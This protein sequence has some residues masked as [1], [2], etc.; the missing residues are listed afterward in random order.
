MPFYFD[1][2][3][4][5]DCLKI[6]MTYRPVCFSFLAA[7]AHQNWILVNNR[8]AAEAIVGEQPFNGSREAAKRPWPMEA[9]RILRRTLVCLWFDF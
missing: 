2:T 7:S 3:Y 9:E 1:G 5:F 6:Y 8:P 4:F